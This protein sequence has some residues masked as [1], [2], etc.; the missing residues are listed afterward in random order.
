MLCWLRLWLVPLLTSLRL[1][2]APPTCY[3]VQR[4]GLHAPTSPRDPVK[5]GADPSGAQIW[6]E[7]CPSLARA[8]LPLHRLTTMQACGCASWSLLLLQI[9]LSE[10]IVVVG[11]GSA[12]VEMAAEIKTE[13]P[14]KEVRWPS[15]LSFFFLKIYNNIK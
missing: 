8:S 6:M 7:R 3:A 12:G 10:F 15:W 1:H 9:Q 13:Y 14:K 4:T 5:G 11:G 2:A